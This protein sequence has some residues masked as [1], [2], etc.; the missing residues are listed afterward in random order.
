MSTSSRLRR[1]EQRRQAHGSSDQLAGP[2]SGSRY[3]PRRKAPGFSL[4]PLPQSGWRAL[5]N[6]EPL[7]EGAAGT[8]EGAPSQ[9]W[10][11]VSPRTVGLGPCRK[12]RI[13]PMVQTEGRER[14]ASEQG[15]EGLCG[16][17]LALKL[18]CPRPR[19]G[20]H[21]SWGGCARP[22]SR[23]RCGGHRAA[24]RGARARCPGPA[25]SG[26]A[27]DGPRPGRAGRALPLWGPS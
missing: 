26:G 25:S 16:A 4:E 17:H 15:G 3:S 19:G 2:R 24:D 20:P 22:P 10:S 9:P 27:C 12:H 14:P 1:R 11:R 8:T 23:G 21:P 6:K 7:G 13:N 5:R 18:L